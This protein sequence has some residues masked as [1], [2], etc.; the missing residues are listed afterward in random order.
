[1]DFPVP[2]CSSA[3]SGSL[4]CFFSLC[5]M[6]G[7]FAYLL[8]ITTLSLFVIMSALRPP[9]RLD[10]TSLDGEAFDVWLA[11][12][13]DYK[14]FAKHFSDEEAKKD[15]TLEVSLFLTIAGVQVRNLVKGLTHD[16]TYAGI[17]EAIKKYI[18]PFSNVVVERNKFFS[19][20]QEEGEDL[21]QFLVRLKQQVNK[22][23]FK[24]TTVDTV[25]NQMVRDQF[26]KGLAH[27]RIRECLLKDGKLTLK[28]AE[29]LASSMNA[30]EL[31]N[32]DF[33]NGSGRVLA[34]LP[35]QKGPHPLRSRSQSSNRKPSGCFTCGKPGH[36]ARDCYKNHTCKNCRKVGHLSLIHI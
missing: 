34:T 11:A 32:K 31:S 33:E 14:R 17:T 24:D 35:R 8:A 16:G 26:I 28:N 29:S 5:F 15:P 9:E 23:D 19:L 12:Y 6:I 4:S 7:L 30:A 3:G 36:L 18:R 21:Q 10:P 27:P 2:F 20:K 25:D 13:S 22:C 1:M